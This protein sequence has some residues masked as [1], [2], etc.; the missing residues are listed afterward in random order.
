MELHDGTHVAP[1][2][3]T[4][5]WPEFLRRV[6]EGWQKPGDAERLRQLADKL[7]DMHV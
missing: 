1:N 2:V 7:E 4:E 3:Y 6:A 5:T